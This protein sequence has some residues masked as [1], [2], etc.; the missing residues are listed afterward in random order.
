MKVLLTGATGFV[1][2]HLMQGLTQHNHSVIAAVRSGSINQ[3]DTLGH[4][5]RDEVSP[6]KVDSL[7]DVTVSVLK[8]R[9]VET[10]VHC[11]GLA[12]SPSAT[13]EQFREVNTELTLELARNAAVAGVVRFV[14]FSSIGVNGASSVRPICASDLAAPYDAYTESKHLAEEGLFALAKTTNMEVVVIR[15]PL[16]YGKGAP[17]NFAKLV[18]LAKLPVPLPFGAINNKRSF[19][20]I[21]NLINF[22]AVCISN[23][24][25]ANQVFLVSDG[26]DLSTTEF[27]RKISGAM[28]KRTMLLPV[29]V[30]MLKRLLKP[31]GADSVVEKLAVNLQVDISKNEQLLGWKAPFSVDESLK[32]LNKRR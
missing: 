32:F 6:L 12:H 31:I 23:A 9:G 26:E 16:I 20:S 30:S 4:D 8:E 1:G 2:Q 18:K 22:A 28:S 21:D 5:E 24:T 17:G 13:P 11:A 15:P 29:P 7:G 25:A 19:V 14:F 3:L 10:I 27:L